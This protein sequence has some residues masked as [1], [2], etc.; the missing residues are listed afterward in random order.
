MTLVE[1]LDVLIDV[2]N[3]LA[4]AH[5][6]GIVH[7]DIKPGN[8]RI[9]GDG[10][11]RVM[12]FGIA[13]L[14]SSTMTRTGVMVGTPAYMS[15]EQI[16][17]GDVSP[18]S[19]LFAVGAV[20]YELLVGVQAFR[21]ESLQTVMYK[22]VSAP[23][24]EIKMTVTSLALD[25]GASVTRSLNAIAAKAMAKEVSDRYASAPDMASA[26]S[27][28]RMHLLDDDDPIRTTSLRATVAKAMANTQKA[29]IRERRNHAALLAVAAVLVLVLVPAFVFW[30]RSHAI[31]APAPAAEST[32]A[33][34]ASLSPPASAPASAAAPPAQTPPASMATSRAPSTRE[35]SVL[36]SQQSAALEARR[37]AID[38]GASA[39]QLSAGDEHNRL[40]NALAR[41]GKTADAGNHLGV[42]S[43]QWSASERT[44]R[45]ASV[46]AAQTARA[47]N[48]E[49]PRQQVVAATPA[50]VSA[51]V[52]QAAVGPPAPSPQPASNAAVE[53]GAAV[54]AYARALESRDVGA[55]RSAYRGITP[56]QAKGWEQFFGTLQTLRA[57]L[58]VNGLEV[59]GGSADARLVGTYDYVTAGGKSAQQAVAFQAAFRREGSAWQLVSVH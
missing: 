23:A 20:M 25:R 10:R 6:R 21:G 4:F 11:A 8:I 53:I 42:A 47:T 15:P 30:T 19:D 29:G 54:A 26:L 17:G 46:A 22:I 57:S 34:V 3:G 1:K 56:A 41:Q 39:E 16:T 36:R 31:L 49:A 32:P 38:A 51:P 37:R 13:H 48:A 2:L 24:P 50:V 44:A 7:R 28:V 27:D 43:A 58:S 12:D 52:Q 9:D 45:T 33:P 40:A 14:N 35:L 18:A 55:V 59:N 5:K